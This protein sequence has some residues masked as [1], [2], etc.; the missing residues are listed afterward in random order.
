VFVAIGFRMLFPNQRVARGGE[1]ILEIP[2]PE[3]AQIN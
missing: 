3:R 2:G 1:K